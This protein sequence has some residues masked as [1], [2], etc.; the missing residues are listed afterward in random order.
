MFL[1]MQDKNKTMSRQPLKNGEEERKREKSGGLGGGEVV[2]RTLAT[3]ETEGRKIILLE[4][5]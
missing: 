3:P 4:G 1:H 5:S 2:V